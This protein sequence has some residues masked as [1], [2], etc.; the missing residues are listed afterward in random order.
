MG[1]A[2]KL[3]RHRLSVEDFHA[4]GRAGILTEDDRVELI[5]GE[6]IDMAPIGSFHWSMVTRLSTLLIRQLGDHAIV[7]T[8]SALSLPPDSEP[9]PDIAVLKA[10]PTW[11]RDALPTARDVLLLVEVA[12][13][14][15][16]YDRDIK[17]P[18]YA[19]HGVPEVW[20]FDLQA[21]STEIHLDPG[22]RGYRRILRP[23]RGEALSPA[24]LKKVQLSPHEIWAVG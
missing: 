5:D 16:A 2:E 19:R 14:T 6:L 12:D 18:L 15:L 4:M 1:A 11:Y 22:S 13:T 21:E 3:S 17:L 9:Q 23:D 7:S 24:L 10:H 20:L 8:Q